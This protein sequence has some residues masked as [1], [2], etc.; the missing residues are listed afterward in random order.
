MNV[1]VATVVLVHGGFTDVPS[2]S[3][4]VAQIQ[5]AGVPV[6][7]VANPLRGLSSDAAY[8][9]G[10][11]RAVGGPV[12]MAGHSYGGAIIANAAGLAANAVG[13]AYISRARLYARSPS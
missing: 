3:V 13:L 10:L 2:W 5:A 11:V 12:L 1:T 9:A 4:V 7:A 8:I 6:I